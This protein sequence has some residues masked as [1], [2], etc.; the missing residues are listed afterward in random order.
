MIADPG[1]DFGVL[2]PMDP[3]DDAH[4]RLCEA[5]LEDSGYLLVSDVLCLVTS[6]HALGDGHCEW[7]LVRCVYVGTD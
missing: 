6:A 2:T 3:P 1:E 5:V 4:T 7:R